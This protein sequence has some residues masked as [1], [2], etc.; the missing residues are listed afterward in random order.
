ML[1][2][3]N[4]SHELRVIRTLFRFGFVTSLLLA[5]VWGVLGRSVFEKV[6]TILAMPCGIIWYLMLC[7][8]ML[9]IASEQRKLSRVLTGTW[10]LYSILGS[11]LLATL[12][13]N[14]IEGPF[15]A[16][17]PL[18][19]ATCDYVIVLGG[20]ASQGVNQRFQ[21]NASGD[22]LILAAELYHAGI[23]KRIICTGTRIRELTTTNN[24][25][26]DLSS[27]ILTKLGVPAAV[28]E[29]VDGRTTSEEMKTLGQ[30]FAKSGQ[31]I[32]LVT[33]AWHMQRAMRLA[34]NNGLS[35]Q[36][37]PA[38]FMSGPNVAW[39]A[40]EWLM[41]FIP[42]ADNFTAVTRISKEYLGMLVGR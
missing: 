29:T 9:A 4:N 25:P 19:E 13:A 3:A 7:G 11:G 41:T 32:G 35:P 6:A 10:L 2:T 31:R 8:I 39:T 5:I 27:T 14:S 24:D 15:Q 37:L 38:D 36:P 28:I 1:T 22:R 17:S 26:G 33:S 30:R 12:L 42:Q 34:E 21:G 20:G 16:V 18:D 40:G 23:A